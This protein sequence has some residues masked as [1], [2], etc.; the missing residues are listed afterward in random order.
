M[1]AVL[2]YGLVHVLLGLG[3]ELWAQWERIDG[4]KV[5]VRELF[6]MLNDIMEGGGVEIKLRWVSVIQVYTRHNRPNDWSWKRPGGRM[7]I[8]W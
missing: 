1:A 3:I 2:N 6:G 4:C 8:S 7:D 5:A